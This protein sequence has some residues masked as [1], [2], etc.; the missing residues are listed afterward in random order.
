MKDSFLKAVNAEPAPPCDKFSCRFRSKCASELLACSAFKI[1]VGHGKALNPYFVYGANGE[2]V[3][4]ASEPTKPDYEEAMLSEGP[5][6]RR[7]ATSFA[8]WGAT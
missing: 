5:I 4:Q 6:R 2:V 7:P 8:S 3:G 1:Y